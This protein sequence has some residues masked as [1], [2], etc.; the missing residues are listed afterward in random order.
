MKKRLLFMLMALAPLMAC[1]NEEGPQVDPI[2]DPVE[3]PE[4]DPKAELPPLIAR[5]DINLTEMEKQVAL[6]NNSFA[7]KLL[8]TVYAD[9]KPDPNIIL[10]PLSASLALSMLNNGAAGETQKEIQDALGYGNISREEL[11]SY[12]QKMMK[13]LVGLDTRAVFENANSI[14]INEEFPVLEAFKEVNQTYYGAEIRNEDFCNPAT[15]DL[16]NGWVNEKTHAKIPEILDEISTEAVMYLINALY[17][18]GYWTTP[19]EEELTT[20]I[21]F[22]NLDGTSPALPTM[23]A[24]VFGSYYVK[25][26]SCSL[27]ELP[28]GN[29]AFS[30]V[31]L[32]PDEDA[33]LS[34]IVGKINTDW[35]NDYLSAKHDYSVRVQLF[36]PR[37]KVEYDRGLIE[38]F[39]AL[40]MTSMF[41]PMADFTLIHPTASLEATKVKQKTFIEVNEKGMEAAAATVI[42]M[43][44]TST[45]DPI[46][47]I[48]LHV[49]R[50]FLIFFKEKSTGSIIFT[51]IIRN[52]Q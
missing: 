7:F 31:V 33:S 4:K 37:F 11:N 9:E 36:L 10:S 45:G 50:P 8:Q 19:F 28:F 47:Y 32:L 38:D 30:M 5:Q 35:W 16:I 42:G 27:L 34:D 44:V 39:K 20:N 26:E 22:H 18:K 3:N 43:E 52:L 17:F 15:L 25:K 41:T 6:Q 46:T 1:Q 40:G 2:P 21:T 48:D 13:A 29:E 12:A 24:S 23:K 51:G 14:W 49:D